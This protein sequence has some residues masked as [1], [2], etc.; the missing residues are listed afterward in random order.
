[1]LVSRHSSCAI[2]LARATIAST[3]TKT[4]AWQR[5]AATQQL[6]P[7]QLNPPPLLTGADLISL[8]LQ[9]GPEFKRLLER[10][11]AAQLDGEIS[12]S[13]EALSAIS[14]RRWVDPS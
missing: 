6:P 5:L 13:E 1:L 2:E 3:H 4:A 11:R 14:E 9:P 8:G 7:A 10:A 12:S